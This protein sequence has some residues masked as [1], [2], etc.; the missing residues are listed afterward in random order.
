MR[1]CAPRH[2][3][4][5]KSVL[6]GTLVSLKRKN[7]WFWRARFC[8]PLSMDRLTSMDVFARIV[9]SG[10]FAGAARQAQLSPTVVSKHVH[11]LESWL[12]ERLPNRSTR[13]VALTE[14]GEAFYEPIP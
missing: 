5:S 10:S 3:M 1:Q 2:I 9:A 6:L 7:G 11:A 8:M 14:A 4:G 13:R 12:G